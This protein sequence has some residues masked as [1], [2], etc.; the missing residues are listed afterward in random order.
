MENDT[1]ASIVNAI[2]KQRLCDQLLVG[3]RA[4]ESAV[5]SG[6]LPAWWFDTCERLIGRPLNRDCFAFSRKP[7]EAAE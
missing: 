3:P 1:P 5:A 2:G 4:V 7:R 6:S